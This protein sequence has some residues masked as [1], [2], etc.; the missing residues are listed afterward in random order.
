[1]TLDAALATLPDDF[2]VPLVLR[3]VVG[4]D[5]AEIATMLD[6]PGGTVRSRIARARSRL[7]D[8]VGNQH[9]PD[10]RPTTTTA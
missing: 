8:V 10:E 3:D 6:I 2:R 4:H 9:P 1:M 5:Y 7:A